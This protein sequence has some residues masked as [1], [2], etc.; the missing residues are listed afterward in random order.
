MTEFFVSFPV[1]G[2]LGACYSIV[3]AESE[4]DARMEVIGRLGQTGWY[5]VTRNPNDIGIERHNLTFVEWEQAVALAQ[6][7]PVQA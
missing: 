4:L 1:G 5:T 3:A 7:W 6:A 2:A